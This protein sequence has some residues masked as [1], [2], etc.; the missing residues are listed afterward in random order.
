MASALAALS[1]SSEP[2]RL[3]K[4]EGGPEQADRIREALDVRAADPEFEAELNRYEAGRQ[5][6]VALAPTSAS[7]AGSAT[8]STGSSVFDFVRAND[9]RVAC[10]A[11]KRADLSAWASSR[12]RA[13]ARIDLPKANSMA[14]AAE[15]RYA[16]RYRTN[17]S[18]AR[19]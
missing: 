18:C 7:A 1:A 8:A 5:K 16:E 10:L 13:P 4:P 17:L 9:G 14:V 3:L 19:T 15:Q 11:R 6:A 12:G 2:W